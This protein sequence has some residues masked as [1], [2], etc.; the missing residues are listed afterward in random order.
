MEDEFNFSLLYTLKKLYVKI[1]TLVFVFDNHL[2]FF[3]LFESFLFP[4]LTTRSNFSGRDDRRNHCLF[5][6]LS[7]SDTQNHTDV[8]KKHTILT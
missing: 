7:F 6:R 2:N 5:L 1:K 3:I 8:Q 4:S